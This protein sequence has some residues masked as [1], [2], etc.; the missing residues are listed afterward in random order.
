M[1]CARWPGGSVL[2]IKGMV[3]STTICAT[4]PLVTSGPIHKIAIEDE[5]HDPPCRRLLHRN[6][7]NS[8]ERDDNQVVHGRRRILGPTLISS[9]RTVLTMFSEIITLHHLL[10]GSSLS[11]PPPLPRKH[12]KSQPTAASA[13]R[14]AISSM[15]NA[16]SDANCPITLRR[17]QR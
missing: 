15:S 3:L 8:P 6:R 1:V 2:T 7:Q 16:G 17:C 5:S 13:S 12:D 10:R 14:Q 11:E 4:T 9:C